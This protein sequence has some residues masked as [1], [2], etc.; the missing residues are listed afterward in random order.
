MDTKLKGSI[1][2]IVAACSL[3]I[4]GIFLSQYHAYKESRML[5]EEQFDN[6]QKSIAKLTALRIEDDIQ[7]LIRELE[8]LSIKPAVKEIDV[9]KSKEIFN[10]LFIRVENLYVNDV[11]LLDSRGIVKLPLMAPQLSGIDFSFRKYFKKA[12]ALRKSVPAYEFIEFKG[13]DVGKK[14]IV[15]AMPLFRS[16]GEFNGAVIF[17]VKINE[18]VNGFIPSL[19]KNSDYWVV[20]DS[21]NILYHPLKKAKTVFK[22]LCNT[23]SSFKKFVERSKTSKGYNTRCVS[24]EGDVSI[25]VSYPLNIAGQPCLF[26]ISTPL[27]SVSGFLS[28]IS[29]QY[30]ITTA[31]MFLAVSGISISIISF[32]NKWNFALKDEI[33]ERKDA[34]K[35]LREGEEKYRMLFNSVNDAVLVHGITEDGIPGKFTASNDI[36]CN[37]YGYSKEEFAEMTPGDINDP[38]RAADPIPIVNKLLKEKHVLFETVDKKKDG[39]SMIVEISAHLFESKGKPIIISAIRDIT[40]RKEVEKNLIESEARFRGAFENA[41]VGAS[42]VDLKG[43]FIKVNRALCKMLGYSEEELLSKTFSEITHPDDVQTGLDATKRL[44]SGEETYTVIEKRYVRKDGQLINVIISPAIIRDSDDNPQY[45]VALFQDITERKKAERKV[46]ASLQEKEVLL[47]EIH[48]RVKNNMA[49]VS[50]LLRLQSRYS[51]NSEI[52]RLLKDSR[53]RIKSMALVHEKLYESESLSNVNV[54]G[55]VKE[56]ATHLLDTYTTKKIRVLHEIDDIELDIDHIIPMGLILNELLS[57]SIEHA[58]SGVKS[59][60][61][62]INLSAS[63]GVANL[64]YSD[65]GAGLP[66][67]LSLQNAQSFGLKIVSMLPSQLKGSINLDETN[68][69]RFTLSFPTTKER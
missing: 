18:L 23:N 13:V 28:H 63:E 55:Y 22:K 16:G 29:F 44:V 17:T 69:A 3:S 11:A 59:P 9:K 34:E 53:N 2:I 61:I 46:A 15:I 27:K 64:I 56:L 52:K 35:L 1:I 50:S 8:L 14:G 48:H 51:S 26:I 10:E 47:T 20:D 45:F 21:G 57:N 5:I 38:K 36:A 32:I 7:L 24:P 40:E 67:E 54:Q 58:F 65:N 42:M 62:G 33:S 68:R 30:A 37:L 39:S 66:K 6:Q 60:E 12:S 41:A 31:I 49:I 43:Q 19:G 25:A 4:L